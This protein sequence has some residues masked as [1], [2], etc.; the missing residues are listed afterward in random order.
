MPDYQQLADCAS[1]LQALRDET[2]A[3]RQRA[4]TLNDVVQLEQLYRATCDSLQL[5]YA[6]SAGH[7]LSQGIDLLQVAL[8]NELHDFQT[9]LTVL[10]QI[11]ADQQRHEAERGAIA[12][13]THDYVMGLRN[14]AHANQMRSQEE[15]NRRWSAAF[16]YRPA[17]CCHL[18][19]RPLNHWGSCVFC[20]HR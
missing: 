17:A 18:C 20:G 3:V 7:F 15:H 19:A 11:Q 2:Q 9:A 8:Q 6:Q 14:E 12:Q 4:A 1:W 16:N 5:R 10:A 13:Q